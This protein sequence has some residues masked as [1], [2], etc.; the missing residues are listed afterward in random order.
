MSQQKQKSPQELID[1]I[2]DHHDAEDMLLQE[3]EKVCKDL[4]K[5]EFDIEPIEDEGDEQI[6][7]L[8]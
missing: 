7:D 6:K 3:L 2:R 4:P 5:D 1:L 8:I